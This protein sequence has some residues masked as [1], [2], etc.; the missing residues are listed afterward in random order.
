MP[1]LQKSI[2]QVGES[3]EK[4]KLRVHKSHLKETL[5]KEALAAGQHYHDPESSGSEEELIEEVK[6]T[7]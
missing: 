3:Y 4:I 5:K 6:N 7:A 1:D 2:E